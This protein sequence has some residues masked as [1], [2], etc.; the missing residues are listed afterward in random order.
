M[1][2]WVLQEDKDK[3][4]GSSSPTSSCIVPGV[5]AS[6]LPAGPWVLGFQ[7]LLPAPG[8]KKVLQG[9]CCLCKVSWLAA[10]SPAGGWP[11]SDG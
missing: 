7:C 2:R 9:R 3:S 5:F 10:F 8:G 6:F 1:Q 11:W 4:V